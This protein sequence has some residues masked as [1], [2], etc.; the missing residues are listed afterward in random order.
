MSQKS[1]QKNS[2][3]R[4]EFI[5]LSEAAELVGYTPEYLNLL[6]R[7]GKL[8]AEKIGRNWHT[9]IIWLD[10]FLSAI[11]DGAKKVV[12]QN[13]IKKKKKQEFIS[14]ERVEEKAVEKEINEKQNNQKLEKL[15]L[16]KSKNNWLQLFVVLSSTVII[17]PLLFVGT[18]I[19]K[20]FIQNYN[21]K[22]NL[23]KIYSRSQKFGSQIVNES[24]SL[25]KVAAAEAVNNDYQGK[26]LASEN[27]K[28]D[29]INFGGNLA[30]LAN[31]KNVPLEINNIKSKSF[32]DNK[33]NEVYL[34]VSWTTNKMAI[35]QLEYSKN[36]GQNPRVAKEDS[37]GF[38]HSVVLAGLDPG[39]SYVY[40][41][42]SNDQWG[43]SQK[44][45]Y[46][47]IYTASNPLS[48]FDLISNA[49]GETFGW[50]IKK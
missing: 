34:V 20:N 13:K 47:G 16:A 35:S 50:A 33:K 19:T 40:Q 11:P 12:A 41:V 10:D 43:N 9:K 5:P 28:I 30:V 26:V 7:K 4:E 6:S 24:T 3:N 8:K 45:K 27:Y 44:S 21:N 39:T 42:K 49:I 23:T 2:Q 32:V 38:N 25:G 14:I 31:K 17:L 46:F 37:Y 15:N 29:T 36:N 18:Y 22:T 48:V 1:I